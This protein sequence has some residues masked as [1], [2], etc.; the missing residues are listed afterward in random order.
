MPSS[1]SSSPPTVDR[2]WRS[3][4][5]SSQPTSSTRPSGRR[6]LTGSG[7]RPVDVKGYGDARNSECREIAP[8][9]GR[10]PQ[11]AASDPP[12]ARQLR[13]VSRRLA[14]R[15]GRARW[16]QEPLVDGRR[17]RPACLGIDHVARGQRRVGRMVGG[18][19][20]SDYGS[21]WTLASRASAQAS[22][23]PGRICRRSAWRVPGR[24]SSDP[25]TDT[26]GPGGAESRPVLGGVA[27]DAGVPR[28]AGGTES[29]VRVRR[30][31]LPAP[32]GMN[33]GVCVP[34]PVDPAVSENL[35]SRGRGKR[36]G[37]VVRHTVPGPLAR[38]AAVPP[39]ARRHARPEIPAA[40]AERGSPVAG[41]T[42]PTRW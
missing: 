40:R 7:L 18:W 1:R 21:A 19:K 23:Y 37:R 41:D 2:T 34:P 29:A 16:D 25:R 31:G 10:P 30:T 8:R 42:R 38:V 20:E 32:A 35:R 3:S 4:T 27:G 9:E 12:V 5:T 36:T 33:P 6:S 28:E 11:T 13:V 17:D 22:L 39:P 15:W 26:E 24:A 14:G